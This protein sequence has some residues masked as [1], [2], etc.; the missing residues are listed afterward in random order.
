MFALSPSVRVAWLGAALAVCGLLVVVVE[1][2]APQLGHSPSRASGTVLVATAKGVSAPGAPARAIPA[3]LAPDPE[4]ERSF[5]QAAGDVRHAAAPAPASVGARISP[6]APSDAQIKRDLAQ[7]R[8]AQGGFGEAGGGSV[9]DGPGLAHAPANA[10]DVVRRVMAGGNAIAD[11]PYVWGGGH[12]SF[13]DSAY[14][15][16]GSVSYALAAGGLLGAPVT[17][18]ALEH[19]GAP[20]PGKWITVYANA[21]HT[22]MY[23]AGIRFDTSGRSGPL[24]SRWQRAPRSTAGFVVRHWPGL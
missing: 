23:V 16:S 12:A 20:G 9:G 3:N 8:R 24:G 5:P 10:P 15:C 22:F 14:D 18:G 7:M 11:F 6:G 21:G 1:R 19:W 2:R 13:T 4:A 17:S